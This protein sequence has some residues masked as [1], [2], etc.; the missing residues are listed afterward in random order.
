MF[1]SEED[2]SSG[3]AG[4]HGVGLAVKEY[5]VREGK[6]T[7]ELTNKHLMSMTFQL[8]RQVQRYHFSCG[9]W[10]D[11]VSSTREQKDASW[12]DLENAVS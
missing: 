6:W 5:I 9:I 3:R 7:Q 8:G 11:N 1:C 12:S 2:G 4:Q 10:P